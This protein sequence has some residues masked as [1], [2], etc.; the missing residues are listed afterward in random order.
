MKEAR[1]ILPLVLLA[2]S[3]CC[4]AGDIEPNVSP[5]VEGN[6]KFALTFTR[7]C[8]LSRAIFFS[9]LTAYR[10]LLRWPMQEHEA[11]QKNRCVRRFVFQRR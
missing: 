3:V 4:Y 11:R 6:N 8:K 5:V 2:I 7:N 10:P 9:R 1:S